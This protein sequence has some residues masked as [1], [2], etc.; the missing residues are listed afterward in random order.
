MSGLELLEDV[1]ADGLVDL[2]QRREVEVAAEELDQ[3]RPVVRLQ[4]LEQVAEVGFVEI[5]DQLAQALRVARLDRLASGSDE[6]RVDL[7]FL[8]PEGGGSPSAPSGVR[9]AVS[10]STSSMGRPRVRIGA[11]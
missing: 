2:G 6:V 7:A 9:S 8:V 10:W 4:R 5:L 11:F 1:L 3:P